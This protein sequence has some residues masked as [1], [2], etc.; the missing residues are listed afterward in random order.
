MLKLQ[1]CLETEDQKWLAQSH[2]TGK[3]RSTQ[4]SWFLFFYYVI[5]KGQDDSAKNLETQCYNHCSHLLD[6]IFPSTDLIGDLI[7]INDWPRI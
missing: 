7:M 5:N 3:S 6:V 4:D 1:E 2:I